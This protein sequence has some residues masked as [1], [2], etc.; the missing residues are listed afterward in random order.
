MSVYDDRIEVDSPGILYDGLNV[1]EALSGKSKCRN[2]AIAEAFQYMKIIE[3]WGD[4]TSSFV[5]AK[6]DGAS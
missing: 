5:P 3:G 6:R 4:G 1:A 2:K